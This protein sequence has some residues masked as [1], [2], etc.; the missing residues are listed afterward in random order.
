M[1]ILVTGGAG[2]IGSHTVDKLIQLGHEVRILDS[3]QKPVH[4]YGKPNWLSKDA[5]FIKGDVR[6]RE[7]WI[8]ALDGI[9]VVYHFAAYQDYLLDFS[10]FFHVNAVGTSLLYETALAMKLD[11]S[12]VIVASS[13]FV[14]GE[15]LYKCV[16]CGTSCV[17]IMRSDYQ[18]VKCNWEH[19]CKKCNNKL[20]WQWTKESYSSPPNAYAIAKQSQEIQAITFGK[21]YNIPSVALRYSIVQG[22]RQSFYNAYSGAC[23]IFALNY[24]FGKA[25]ILY[26]D[27]LQCRDFVNIYDVV[28][29]NIM[30]L[31]NEKMNYSV[32]N[33][34][35]GHSYT[36]TEF[37]EIVRQEFHNRG[38]KNL[39]LPLIP[40]KYRF[41]DT[42]NACSN[43][44][45]LKSLGW[46]PSKTPHDSVAD[47]VEWLYH[48]KNVN[49]ILDFA[50]KTMKKHNIVKQGK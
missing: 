46:K 17:P 4:L 49:D 35:G 2:F 15:G 48:Q 40:K 25:P 7:D 10:T 9:D 37:A 14:Q 45:K 31:K 3:L 29:A 19:F 42:R 11:L 50:D 21:R 5:E 27:G 8:K 18:L 24:Y 12:K 22:P 1:R 30:A 43:I 38:E 16:S 23:R 26:E 6:N 20:D 39:P 44:G 34:G 47:Y 36:I 13:Q 32:F 41:G 28:E 33:V